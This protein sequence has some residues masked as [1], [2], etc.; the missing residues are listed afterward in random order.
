MPNRRGNPNLAEARKGTLWKPGQTGNP[1]GRGIAEKIAREFFLEKDAEK[2]KKLL[3]HHFL[4][5]MGTTSLAPI[6]AKMIMDRAFG[7]PKQDVSIN[8]GQG[9]LIQVINPFKPENQSNADPKG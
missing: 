5:A 1:S 6:S 4:I 9:L 7:P 2:L 8:D 3:A